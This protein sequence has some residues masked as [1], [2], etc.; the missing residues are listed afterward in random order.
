MSHKEAMSVTTT[1]KLQ[2]LY[3]KASTEKDPLTKMAKSS[4]N[5][6]KLVRRRNNCCYSKSN[7]ACIK[8]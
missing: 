3:A 1:K 8:T 2:F 5:G 7:N 4:L 6:D